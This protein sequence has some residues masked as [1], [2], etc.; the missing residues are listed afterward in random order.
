MNREDTL[1]I[2]SVL[3][4]A[5]PNY[6]KDM[7]KVEAEGI[8]ALWTEMFKDEPAQLVAMAVKS[9]IASDTKGFPPHIGAIKDSMLKLMR[10]DELTEAEAWAKVRKAIGNSSYHAEEEY[11]KLPDILQRL[12]GSPKQLRE[13]A[14][15]DEG[16]LASV[17]A[18][19][20]QRSFRA[21][22]AGD[23]EMQALPADIRQYIQAIG[24]GGNGN[25]N[26]L[27][28]GSHYIEPR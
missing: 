16:T 22:T 13:W 8:V 17:V 14:A 9:F 6:Y 15:M 19:N 20:F 27:T 11:N 23:R 5:Y 12:C 4:A 3:K 25:G 2:M 28:A 10:G 21:R 1:K 26:R 18:S 24:N 7:K